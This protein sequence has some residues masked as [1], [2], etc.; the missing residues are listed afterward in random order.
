MTTA[1]SELFVE[2]TST[3]GSLVLGKIQAHLIGPMKGKLPAAGPVIHAQLA[4]NYI[5]QRGVFAD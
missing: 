4:L 5:L 1:L 3:G 2:L